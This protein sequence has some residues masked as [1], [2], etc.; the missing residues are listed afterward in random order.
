MTRTTRSAFLAALGAGAAA[1]ALPRRAAA[2]VAKIQMGA[3][4]SDLF[5]EPFFLK[6]AGVFARLGIDYDAQVVNN[7]GAMAAA[8]AGGAIDIGMGDLVSPVNAINAGL[9]MVIIAGGALYLSTESTLIVAVAKNSPVKSGRDLAGK[10]IGVPTLVGL[11][12][13]SLKAWLPMNG[14]DASKAKIVE[15]PQSAT[16]AALQRGTIDAGAL[17]EPFIT[18]AA[19]D[20]RDIGHPLDAIAPR[21]LDSAWYAAKSWCDADPARVKKV[22]TAIYESA[23]WCNAHRAATLS[24]FAERQKL[25]TKQLA[26]MARATWATSLDAALIQ[27]VLNLATKYKIFDRA[28]DANSLI[29]RG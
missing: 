29:Y 20:V 18:L 21:F 8:V 14:V 3:P 10:T 17:S 4:F 15:I 19:G 6:D 12:T 24:I 11:S 28:V 25:D 9:P 22:V 26:G 23:T 2:Q 16:V 5:A 27:P 1:T 13:A 7:A